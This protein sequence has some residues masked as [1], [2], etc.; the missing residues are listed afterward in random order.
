MPVLDKDKI[1]YI[2]NKRN[3]ENTIGSRFTGRGYRKDKEYMK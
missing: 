1:S 2:V 3:T